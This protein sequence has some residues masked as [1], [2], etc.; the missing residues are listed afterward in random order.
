MDLG[1]GRGAA[2]PNTDLGQA[3]HG[4]QGSLTPLRESMGEGVSG[5]PQDALSRHRSSGHTKASR[6]ASGGMWPRTERMNMILSYTASGGPGGGRT[7]VL[8]TGGT[9]NGKAQGRRAQP[10]V[11]PEAWKHE[12]ETS[13]SLQVTPRRARRIDRGGLSGCAQRR[14]G[15]YQKHGGMR[16]QARYQV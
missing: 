9:L 11:R 1:S 7:Q 12:L 15:T 10:A 3:N 8:I 16:R 14:S 5:A 2:K 6:S 13:R 4:S